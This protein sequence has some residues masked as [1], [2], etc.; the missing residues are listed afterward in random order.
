MKRQ[1]NKWMH[2]VKIVRS[3]KSSSPDCST[4]GNISNCFENKMDGK[5]LRNS[6]ESTITLGFDEDWPNAIR[7]P[8]LREDPENRFSGGVISITTF[9]FL[10]S[11]LG[12]VFTKK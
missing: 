4:T 6:R 1:K 7:W 9:P 11:K 8:P 2:C 10:S 5:A 12:N 3:V